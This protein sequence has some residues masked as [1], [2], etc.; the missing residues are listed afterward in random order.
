MRRLVCSLLFCLTGCASYKATL[1]DK[2]GHTT[3]ASGKNGIITG[4]H[5]RGAFD[6]CVAAAK[7]Q[8][9]QPT[10]STPQ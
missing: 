2:E 7:A 9:Y 4:S 10:G 5:V 6:D 1:T 3:E 8:G